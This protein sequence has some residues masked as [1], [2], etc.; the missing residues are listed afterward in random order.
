M[1]PTSARTASEPARGRS[2]SASDGSFRGTRSDTGPA[3]SKSR[4]PLSNR[5]R[6]PRPPL[7]RLALQ[8]IS[9]NAWSTAQTALTSP[10]PPSASASNGSAQCAQPTAH[11]WMICQALGAV[12]DAVKPTPSSLT[13]RNGCAFRR[14]CISPLGATRHRDHGALYHSCVRHCKLRCFSSPA[15]NPRAALE[16]LASIV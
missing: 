1:A 5:P 4:S 10:S 14:A 8:R 15:R 16:S 2:K 9:C 12:L 7:T 13:Q 6:V 11:S 3:R